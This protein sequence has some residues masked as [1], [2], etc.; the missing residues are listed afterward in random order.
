MRLQREAR[1]CKKDMDAQMKKTGKIIDNFICL[2]DPENVYAW[3]FVVFGIAEPIEFEG[4]YYMGV[5]TCPPE[6]PAKAPSIR[7]F[8]ESGRFVTTQTICLSISDYH[9]ES[10]NP[11]WK[12]SQIIIGMLS[13]WIS[14]EHTYGAS[15]LRDNYQGLTVKEQ[16]IKMA[17]NSRKTVL[18]HAKFKE[19]FTPYA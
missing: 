4:G 15:R 14:D 5:I 17:Q 10:W 1:M 7:L 11:A 8:T 16:R 19:L 6:Y 2:P 9:P 13:F 12:V 18:E 3:Y